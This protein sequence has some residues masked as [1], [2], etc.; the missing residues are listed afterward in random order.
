MELWEMWYIDESR[1]REKIIKDY[2][3]EYVTE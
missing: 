1:N 2:I 3:H